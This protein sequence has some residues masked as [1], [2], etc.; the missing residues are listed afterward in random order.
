MS[1]RAR[2][3]TFISALVAVAGLI[4]FLAP[5]EQ[6]CEVA[7]NTGKENCTAHHMPYFLAWYI[8]TFLDDHNGAVAAVAGLI[9]AGF[10]FALWR[11]T[12]RMQEITAATLDHL[13]AEFLATHRPQIIVR[14]GWLVPQ[15][16][17][18]DDVNSHYVVTYQLVNVG[19]SLAQLVSLSVGEVW[20]TLADPKPISVD[21]SGDEIDRSASTTVLTPG[22]KLPQL[23]L[24]S[25]SKE[26]YFPGIYM[27]ERYEYV[28][29][30]QIVYEDAN[31][32][33]R[34]TGFCRRYDAKRK[35][36]VRVDDPDYEYTD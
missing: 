22:E 12:R 32:T 4:Y 27:A 16:N 5:H 28:F 10:T 23:H 7:K 9:V 19:T 3:W 17:P 24:G 11:S 36:F 13:R 33:R 31:H 15:S 8:G 29:F 30:G 2:L 18:S 20:D 14:M 35:R 21:L 25:V 34:E 6:V 1:R 26:R